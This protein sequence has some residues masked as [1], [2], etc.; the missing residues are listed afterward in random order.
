[1]NDI[2]TARRRYA[3]RIAAAAGA[4]GSALERAFEAVPREQFIGPPPWLI[5]GVSGF[6]QSDDPFALYDDV[7]VA[8]AADRGINNGQ[9]SLHAQCLAA[10]AIRQGE[11]VIHAGA[12]TGYYT[13]ILSELVGPGGTVHAYELER[14][15]AEIAARNLAHRPLVRVHADSVC[16]PPLPA[17]DVMYVSAG[18][19]H[20]PALWLDALRANGRLLF[21]LTAD[22]GIGAMLLVTH[23]GGERYR[24][25]L[26]TSVAFIACRGAR[27]P[28]DAAV[29]GTAL[30]TRNRSSVKSLWRNRPPDE[31]AWCV[32]AD[33]WLSTAEVTAAR[34][35]A[36][37][38][39]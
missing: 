36:G 2:L 8:L 10:L 34:G 37:A 18:A 21:P 6:V 19:S 11:T 39:E 1:M 4:G 33:W 23:L 25:R 31:T 13:A 7:L 17:T 9:P 16:D 20:P 5:D 27:R 12:G 26:F 15:L 29:V 14:D 30:R 24:A 35:N 38:T 22:D 3:Q 32:G 28:A